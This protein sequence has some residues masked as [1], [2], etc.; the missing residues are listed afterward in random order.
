MEAYR[1]KTIGKL[2]SAADPFRGKVLGSLSQYQTYAPMIRVADYW[3]DWT[4]LNPATNEQLT[5]SQT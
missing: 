4:G 1:M 5:P 3:R 2:H